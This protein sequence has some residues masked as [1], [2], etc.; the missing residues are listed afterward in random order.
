MSRSPGDSVFFG[1]PAFR[2]ELPCLHVAC[3]R[4]WVLSLC[5]MSREDSNLTPG[6][7]YALPV[8][9]SIQLGGDSRLTDRGTAALRSGRPPSLASLTR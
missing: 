5:M 2:G 7:V 6:L 8:D 3:V 1:Q 9:G 4:S